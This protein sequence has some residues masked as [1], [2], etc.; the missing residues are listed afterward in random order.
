M[1][2]DTLS[3]HWYANEKPGWHEYSIER[4]TLSS[5][6]WIAHYCDIVSWIE[7]SIDMPLRHARWIIHPENALFRFRYER[8]YLQF[9]LRWA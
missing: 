4:K 5:T 8:N 1:Q 9:V 7:E 6:K 3:I 2:H